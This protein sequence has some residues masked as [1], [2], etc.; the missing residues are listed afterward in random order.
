[1]I[2]VLWRSET[3]VLF[4]LSYWGVAHFNPF[5]FLNYWVSILICKNTYKKKWNLCIY[6]VSQTHV[7]FIM[8][9]NINTLETI[10]HQWK[11]VMII[12]GRWYTTYPWLY[13]CWLIDIIL[14]ALVLYMSRTFPRLVPT[15]PVLGQN[16]VFMGTQDRLQ[17]VSHGS[18]TC[19]SCPATQLCQSWNKN[20]RATLLVTNQ[21]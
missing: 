8:F 18:V 6:N 17:N 3:G 11:E 9:G 7:V 5:D 2:W 19:P 4:N 1:M 12:E 16:T 10:N 14:V 20:K 21:K 13:L 15:V